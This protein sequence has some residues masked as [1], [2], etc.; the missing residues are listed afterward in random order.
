MVIQS[1][2]PRWLT[3]GKHRVHHSVNNPTRASCVSISKWQVRGVAATRARIHCTLTSALFVLS[4]YIEHSKVHGTNM[5]PIWG[6]QDPGGPHDGSMNLAIWEVLWRRVIVTQ[7][8]YGCSNL[9]HYAQH[10]YIRT[11]KYDLMMVTINRISPCQGN[12]LRSWANFIRGMD[13]S[14]KLSKIVMKL[15]IHTQTPHTQPLRSIDFLHLLIH[16]YTWS[17]YFINSVIHTK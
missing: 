4:K 5:G 16:G 7:Q 2:W 8:K 6:R 3:S 12:H 1:H 11:Q 9:I 15:L 14:L 13:N 10:F 17:I